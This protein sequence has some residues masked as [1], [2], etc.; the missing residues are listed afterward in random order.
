[1][2]WWWRLPEGGG[3]GRSYTWCCSHTNLAALAGIDRRSLLAGAVVSL[4]L[5][6]AGQTLAA[7]ENPAAVNALW[8]AESSGVIKVATA[9]GSLALEIPGL[10]NVRA[11]AVDHHRPTLWLYAG[12][13]LYAYGY[14]G[15]QQLAVPLSL[16]N[17]ANAAL[18]VNEH[19]G[20]IWLGADQNLVSVS[21]SGRRE[22]HLS[23]A[24]GN[25]PLIL[26]TGAGVNGTLQGRVTE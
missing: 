26:T 19:D 11:V 18:A 10:T 2:Q 21:A 16:P 1:M 12:Q 17:P 7:Q 13:N 24:P 20:S 6:A 22:Y 9:D 5:L 3:M 15:T 23:S 8:V 14:D 25:G 4:A